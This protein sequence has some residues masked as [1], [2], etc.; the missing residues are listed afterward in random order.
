MPYHEVDGYLQMLSLQESVDKKVVFN[1][2]MKF[3]KYKK[4]AAD[5]IVDMKS[6][7]DDDN[8][9]SFDESMVGRRR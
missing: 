1:K 2:L 9:V 3:I 6:S 4:M 5:M 8:R 7:N